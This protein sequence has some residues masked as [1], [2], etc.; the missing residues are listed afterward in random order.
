M[1]RGAYRGGATSFLAALRF[2]RVALVAAAGGMVAS[3]CTPSGGFD[4]AALGLGAGTARPGTVAFESID[5]PPEPVFRKL[6]DRLGEE[7]R[8]RKVAMVSRGQAAQYRVRGYVAAHVQGQKTTITW[9]WDVFSA[10]RERV[11]RFTGE[12]PGVAAERAWAAADDAV[13]GRMAQDGMSRLADFVAGATPHDASSPVASVPA[14]PESGQES[15]AFL[16]SSRP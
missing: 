5:G 16:P 7:A 4:M 1:L 3:A 12:V 11:A 15:T 9:V 14:E 2:M 8:T 13:I 6:V 10:G